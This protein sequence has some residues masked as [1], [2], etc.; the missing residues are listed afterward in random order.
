M[1]VIV[2]TGTVIRLLPRIA[3]LSSRVGEWGH[4]AYMA[5]GEDRYKVI[6]KL[7]GQVVSG[8]IRAD[9]DAGYVDYYAKRDG[10]MILNNF[11]DSAVIHRSY[12]VVEITC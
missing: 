1:A 8:C 7:N 6:V 12:G 10:Q 4:K 5:L 11:K 2:P 3:C 9:S